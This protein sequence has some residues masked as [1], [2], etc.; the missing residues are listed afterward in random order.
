MEK[1]WGRHREG[2]EKAWKRHGEGMEN[3]TQVDTRTAFT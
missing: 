3:S 1:A 2:V